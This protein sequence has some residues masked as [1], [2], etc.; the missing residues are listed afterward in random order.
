MWTETLFIFPSPGMAFG[1][2]SHYC[3]IILINM[4]NIFAHLIL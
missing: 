4:S 3:C 1:K 2:C